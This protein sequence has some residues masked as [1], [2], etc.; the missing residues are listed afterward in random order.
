M[1]HPRM[2][3]I[4]VVLL[5]LG[6]LSACGS[7]DSGDGDSATSAS[8]SAGAGGARPGGDPTQLAAIQQCLEAAGLSD[9]MPS[10][11]PSDGG[12]PPNGIPTDMPSGM[13]SGGPA[14]GGQGAF[15]DPEVQAALQ[16]CG[17][18]LPYPSTAPSDQA[19]G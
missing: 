6:T 19:T 4:A 16:A 15:Q 11:M 5:A 12:T 1:T 2:S 10:G 7:D 8:A 9:A 13:P 18:T 17:I 3:A 14:G